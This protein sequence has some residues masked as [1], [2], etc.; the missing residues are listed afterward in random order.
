MKE[1]FE[2][3]K[4]VLN[5]SFQIILFLFL[6]TLLIQQ[7]YPFEVNSTININWFMFAVIIIGALSILF[8]TQ[9]EGDKFH[10]ITWKDYIFVITLGILGGLIIFIKLKDLGWL[11]GVISI[12]GGLTIIFLSWLVLQEK[13]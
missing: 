9:K 4:Q 2:T 3:V 5:Y 6:I 7:F 10:K 1:V 13:D 8:P 11:S 12:L